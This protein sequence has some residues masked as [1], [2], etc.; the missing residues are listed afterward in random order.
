[1]SLFKDIYDRGERWVLS[2]M[3]DRKVLVEAA[4]RRGTDRPSKMLNYEAETPAAKTLKEWKN[5]VTA[6][7]DPE[8][9]DRSQL[10]ELYA[11]LMLDNHLAS[12]IETRIM[13]SQR[14]AFKFIGENDKENPDISKLF[15]RPWF[16][17]LIKIVLMSQFEGTKLIEFFEVTPEGELALIDEIPQ[18][19]FNPQLGIIQ[20]NEGDTTGWNYRDGAFTNQYLQV[21]RDNEL[22]LLARMAPIVLAKK[23]GL[24]AMQDY[25]DKFG[26]PPIF[27]TTDREDDNRLKE[28]FA[29]AGNFKKNHFMVGRGQEKFEIGNIGGQGVAPHEK[30]ID[31]C[32]TE[33]S[34]RILGGSGVVDEKAFVGA[35][36]IQ[37]R[38]A[39]DRFE[40]DKL[41]F[42]YIFNAHIRPILI[43]LSPV[44]KDLANYNFEWDNT[45]SLSQKEII[46][47][48]EKFGSLY[49]IDPEYITKVTGIPILGI[50]ENP[51]IITPDKPA[52]GGPEK[53]KP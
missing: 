22:G 25:V 41:L 33:I 19:H 6:A 48:I 35:A 52:P 13:F 51:T 3:D 29:A 20:K 32:N 53:K 15:E 27:V 44:Y 42:K 37:F 5:A 40:T 10:A 1:M 31:L 21:G 26:V 4:M 7:T 12:V 14:S 24:G 36:E 17:D 18:T 47:T 39:K 49:D 11:N 43:N 9:P 45:E 46:D 38:L 23:L 8:M 30:L 34:K 28:L 2:R 16:G 50:K